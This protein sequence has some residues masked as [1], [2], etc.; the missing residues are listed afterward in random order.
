[1]PRRQPLSPPVCSIRQYLEREFPGQVRH[2]GW[3]QGLKS[4]VFEIAHETGHH[5]V[6]V[7]EGLLQSNRDIEAELRESELVDYLH[8]ARTQKRRFLVRQDGSTVRIRSTA[9]M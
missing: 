3:E 8:E 6:L 1:M 4:H 7:P 9:L 2:T 5:Q